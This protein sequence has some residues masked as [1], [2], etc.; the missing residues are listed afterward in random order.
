MKGVHLISLPLCA[1]AF[2]LFLY[3]LAVRNTP[4]GHTGK[5]PI[6]ISKLE[7]HATGG[8]GDLETLL[9]R[10][11]ASDAEAHEDQANAVDAVPPQDASG[12]PDAI[13]RDSATI[14]ASMYNAKPFAAE[15][16]HFLPSDRIYLVMDLYNLAAGRHQVSAAWINPEGKTINT[17]EH[18]IDLSAPAPQHRS[19][20]WLELMKNG[21]FTELFTGREYKPGVYGRWKV[22]IHLDGQ[23]A[24]MHNFTIQD[25]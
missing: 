7:I 21:P 15:Q 20:F 6:T 8:A 10:R 16:N 9:E 4:T 11:P 17:S 22:D 12:R 25:G 5:T 1:L 3:W 13:P 23:P 2:V 18:T 14:R 24:G 19:Y